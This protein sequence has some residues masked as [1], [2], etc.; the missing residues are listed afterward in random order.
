MNGSEGTAAVRIRARGLR[1]L[2][3]GHPWVFRDDVSSVEGAS[4]GGLVRVDGPGGQPAGWAFWSE[5]S[6]IAIRHVA[7][8][9]PPPTDETWRSR[10]DRALGHR[11]RVGAG[12]QALRLAFGESDGLPGFV[13]DLYGR[14]L[15]VQ[16]LTASAERMGD[17]LIDAIAERVPV[18]SVLAR[19]DVAVRELE[20][21]PREVR[22]LRGRT[23]ECIEIT[24]HGLRF[25]VDP[26]H[27]QKTGAFLDQSDNREAA[28]RW[29]R[30][31]VLDAFAYE[32]WFGL[33]AARRAREVVLVDSSRAALER[34]R[35]NAS[36]N[37]L[38]N[39][40]FVA[41]NV[42]EDLRARERAGERFDLVLLDPP[43][44]A[45]RRADRIEALR[46]YKE[47]NLRAMRLLAEDGV[48]VTS[49]CSFNLGEETFL[50]VLASAAADA[51]RRMHL[52]ERRGQSGDHP[53]RLGFPESRYL[54]CVVLARA[55]WDS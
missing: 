23:P 19:N 6:K 31:R 33:L 54:K 53:V 40:T 13:A 11:A 27:G 1:R 10:I 3:A 52:V 29:A 16:Y 5:H 46:G 49:S 15:V 35:I 24:E 45:K 4:H 14:H 48:L 26:W 28:A 55:G 37:A 17:A 34:A 20:A 41:G 2:H 30:G 50:E 38:D 9:G 39:V 12:R 21:L 32:G 25:V 42:F 44:F 51:G 43:A 36:M 47:I 22:Q 7:A 18:D 8:A